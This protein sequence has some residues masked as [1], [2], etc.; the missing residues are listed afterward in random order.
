MECTLIGIFPFV[1]SLQEQ[2]YQ[3]APTVQH[4]RLFR[5][6]QQHRDKVNAGTIGRSGA[7]DITH[8]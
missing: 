5:I 8:W 4:V 1:L 6:Q 2:P 7:A 3:A